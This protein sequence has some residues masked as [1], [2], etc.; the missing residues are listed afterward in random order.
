MMGY[1][2]EVATRHREKK[3]RG[4]FVGTKRWQDCRTPF[5][6]KARKDLLGEAVC[7]RCGS[8]LLQRDCR[9]EHQEEAI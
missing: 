4:T 5:C 9:P 8:G 2:S 6:T 1:R 7:R 3:H